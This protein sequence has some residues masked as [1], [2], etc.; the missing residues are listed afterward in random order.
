ME[1]G[2]GWLPCVL[3]RMKRNEGYYQHHTGPKLHP[4]EY[5]TSGRV[6]IGVEGSEETLSYL[7]K[8]V[9]AQVF[10][11]ASDYPHEVDFVAAK[12]EI[13]E[14]AERA[15]LSHEDKQA[16]LGGNAKRFFKL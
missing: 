12:H 5:V 11:Y 7:V 4:V 14:M 2:C 10:A 15:D 9:G 13:Q 16:I 1:G 6:L 3:D 8:R